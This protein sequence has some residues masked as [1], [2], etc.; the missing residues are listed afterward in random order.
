MNPEKRPFPF[1]TAALTA[2]A[3]FACAAWANLAFAVTDPRDFVF[4]P[5][6][7]AGINANG[8]ERF[9]SEY[10]NIARALYA[11]RGFADPFPEQTGPT[12]WMPPLLPALL[13]SLLWLSDGD[14]QFIA[15]AAVLLQV[16][17]LVGAGILI[18][19]IT[20][21]TAHRLPAFLAGIMFLVAM[22]SDFHAWFQ[23]LH[24]YGFILFGVNLLV[25]GLVWLRPLENKKTACAWGIAGGLF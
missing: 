13:A 6:F 17:A 7:Q 23:D 8:N 21:Q 3:I 9:G 16:I 11:G 15:A 22:L 2:L 4:F 19:A 20:H 12:A 1:V 5:P 25:A 18:I 14:G 10:G 24:D